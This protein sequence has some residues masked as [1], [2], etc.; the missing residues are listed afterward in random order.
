MK[1]AALVEIVNVGATKN[2]IE[3][4]TFFN[5]NDK[6]INYKQKI[7]QSSQDLR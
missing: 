4:I 3:L 7:K 5:I 6:K 1:N 2:E